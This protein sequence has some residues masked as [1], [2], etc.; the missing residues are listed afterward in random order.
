MTD[1]QIPAGRMTLEEW[2][3]TKKYARVTTVSTFY[4]TYVVPMDQL[5]A[6]NEDLEAS[7]EWLADEVVMERVEEFS[8][9]HLGELIIDCDVINEDKMLEIFDQQNQYLAGWT[10]EKK[11]EWVRKLLEIG[12]RKYE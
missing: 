1:K 8:Q 5:Q 10:K 7:A 6:F 9:K 11:I 3:K 12:Q 4:H 2:Q